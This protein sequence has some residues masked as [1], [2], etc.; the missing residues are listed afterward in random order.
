MV[1][2][3]QVL[4]VVGVGQGVLNVVGESLGAS[5]NVALRARIDSVWAIATMVSIGIAANLG[6]IRGAAFAHIFTF[7]GLAA[8]YAA[9]GARRIGLSPA[10]MLAAVGGVAGSVGAQA[11]VTAGAA[12]GARALGGGALVAGLTGA[13]LGLAVLMLS[14]RR[15]ARDALR[16]ARGVI[17]AALRR[18]S[19]VAA[20]AG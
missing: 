14:L 11:A 19:P 13:L 17:A 20:T 18:R 6:G 10:G 3:F 16:E 2:P 1:V 9:L 15:F 12:V 5:G 4:L 8:A 7:C